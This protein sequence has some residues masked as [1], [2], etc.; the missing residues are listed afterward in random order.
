MVEDSDLKRAQDDVER[1]L[2]VVFVRWGEWHRF[3]HARSFQAREAARL[4]VAKAEDALVQAQRR[5]AA[6]EASLRA[7][8]K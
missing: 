7:E 3:E 5:A 4:N 1:A 8:G 6:L 2:D